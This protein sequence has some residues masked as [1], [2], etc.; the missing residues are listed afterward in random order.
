[1][2]YDDVLA[3]RVRAVLGGVPALNEIRMFGGLCFTIHGNM[4]VGITADDLMV[5]MGED[6][7]EAALD[8]P[9]VRPMDFTGRP[10]RGFVFVEPEATRDDDG[11][12][13]WVRRGVSFASA[14]P[15]KA[16]RKGKPRT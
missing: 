3:G 2:A 12:R 7:A 9:H 4:A 14:L 11:L 13:T 1:M 8:E 16:P 6:Q 5:R 10:M 15:P